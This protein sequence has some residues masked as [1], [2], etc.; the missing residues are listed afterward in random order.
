[1]L[2]L[3]VALLTVGRVL[4]GRAW[5]ILLRQLPA[6]LVLSALPIVSVAALLLRWHVLRLAGGLRLPIAFHLIGLP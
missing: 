5:R 2:R 4:T 3:P 6:L 1:M